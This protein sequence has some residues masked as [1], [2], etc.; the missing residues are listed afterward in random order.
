MLVQNR[1]KNKLKHDMK[2][3]LIAFREKQR[4]CKAQCIV[5]VG[6]NWNEDFFFWDLNKWDVFVNVFH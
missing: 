2:T 3:V 6:K 1:S 5:I 4:W